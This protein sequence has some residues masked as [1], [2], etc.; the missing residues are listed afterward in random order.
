MQANAFVLRFE[1][2]RTAVFTRL[3]ATSCTAA[4]NPP[5]IYTT[6]DAA[7]IDIHAGRAANLT[8]RPFMRRT[9]KKPSD[10]AVNVQNPISTRLSSQ[11]PFSRAVES[12][13][14]LPLF[15]HPNIA[16]LI[17]NLTAVISYFWMALSRPVF[18][19]RGLQLESRQDAL[20]D[21]VICAV[22]GRLL[23]P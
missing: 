16:M 12:S 19:R 7:P 1:R 13:H 15:W 6:S 3:M 17:A 23:V 11:H 21:D 4:R 2:A 22:R 10:D 20:I 5:P 14:L 8:N 18:S 9:K